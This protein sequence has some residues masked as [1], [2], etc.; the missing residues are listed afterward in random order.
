[1]QRG[2]QSLK[3]KLT[4]KKLLVTVTVPFASLF[5]LEETV[6]AASYIPLPLGGLAVAGGSQAIATTATTAKTL[7]PYYII[8]GCTVTVGVIAAVASMTSADDANEIVRLKIHEESVVTKVF[9]VE[10]DEV[11]PEIIYEP[12]PEPVPIDRTA[13]ILAELAT[14]TT[15]EALQS[16]ID[17][18][19][20]SFATQTRRNS[21]TEQ[22][23]FF[24]TNEGEW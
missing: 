8:A 16:I 7:L 15:P 2:R 6:F 14:A 12:E 23:M 17:Y 19:D 4:N 20:F 13:Q 22:F 18:Y 9:E 11:E 3:T 5:F 1:M 24:V 10:V 21:T